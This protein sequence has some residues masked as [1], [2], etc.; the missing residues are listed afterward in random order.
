M[1]E[2]P[3]KRRFLAPEV[4]Q[5]SAMDCGP[6][7]LKI[8]LE[9]FGVPVSY[10]RLREACHTSVD[11]TSIDTLGEVAGM[12]GLEAEQV[13]LPGE[14]LLDPAA[15]ALPALAVVLQASRMLHFLVIWRRVGPFVQV[16]DPAK[17][18]RWM[19][20]ATLLR[21][22]YIHETAVPAAALAEV[23]A[24]PPFRDPLRHRLADL[25]GAG[26]TAE[27]CSPAAAEDWTTWAALDG[28]TRAVETAAREVDLGSA[29]RRALWERLWAHTR[30]AGQRPNDLVGERW[31]TARPG[32]AGSDEVAVR[33]A[34]ILQ[35]RGVQAPAGAVKREGEGVG[36]VEGQPGKP[37][38]ALAAAL[39][40]DRERP[41]RQLWRLLRADGWTTLVGAA[42]LLAVVGVATVAEAL[43]LRSLVDLGTYLGEFRQRLLA[44]GALL[45]LIATVGLIDWTA[46]RS[47]WGS[48][49]RLELRMRREYLRKIP[50]L[51]DGYFRSRPASDMIERAHLGHRLSLLPPLAGNLFFAAAQLVATVVGLCWL[52]PGGVGWTLLAAASIVAVPWL[53]QPAL[54]EADLRLR[55]HA[56]ALARYYLDALQG[57]T[58]LRA[59]G[60]SRPILRDHDDRLI[61]WAR[62]ARSALGTAVAAETA[63]LLVGS[64]LSAVL[65]LDYLASGTSGWALLIIYWSMSLPEIG[66]EIAFLVQQLPAQRNV[67][68]RLL[69][70]L[71]APEV[72]LGN[73]APSGPGPADVTAGVALSLSGVR[74][75][76]A[77]RT[78]LEL[79]ALEI[80]AGEHLAVVGPSG[81]GKSSLFGLL[82]G[83]VDPTEGVVRVDGQPL[84]AAALERL[85]PQMAWSEPGVQLW[86]QGLLDNL[87]FGGPA[88]A[89]PGGL[90]E[91]AELA[92]VLARLPQGFATGLGEGGRLL[93]G[94]EGQ[95]VRFGRALHRRGARLVLLDE[96]FR[97]LE[98]D[99][100]AR[101]LARARQRFARATL[102]YAT[103]DLQ[104]AASFPRL[105]VVDGGRVVE[106]GPP[107]ALLARP[108]SRLRAMVDAGTAMAERLRAVTSATLRVSGRKVTAGRDE[109]GGTG[110]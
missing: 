15:D 77:G 108:D 64:T 37:V 70:P 79:P 24:T 92:E 57:L 43:L 21:D 61:E 101:L 66:R 74:A 104:E 54:G 50:R 22:L 86:N 93:S 1:S 33:G 82:L 106:D 44:L 47:L 88:D 103:H 95:R 55:T 18:R 36:E 34:V 12:L 23:T 2:G 87:R 27:V 102:L 85:R 65:L 107:A 98:R 110:R 94:G 13:L 83:W 72:D 89:D 75:E 35:V 42:A 5:T 58:A 46:I 63:T 29:Q 26:R 30:A 9:G 40:A 60:A 76:V 39:A 73:G 19:R 96:A 84:T 67:T 4:V 20:P 10:G 16:S 25:L 68:L 38:P 99:R 78:L 105:L 97:G 14:H 71:S 32:P 8:L 53:F 3:G 81:A 28:V 11:G 6:A 51:A 56:G 69:E 80:R 41:A 17:G 59:H 91:D 7:A 48:G 45:I 49:R 109:A 100:R 62:S 90:V 52:H 31:W